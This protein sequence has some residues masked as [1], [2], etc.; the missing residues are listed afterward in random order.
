MRASQ[1]LGVIWW[2]SL[3]AFIFCVIVYIVTM[4]LENTSPKYKPEYQH[5]LTLFPNNSTQ[6]FN[7]KRLEILSKDY[8]FV[9]SHG[10]G[11]TSDGVEWVTD[12][13]DGIKRQITAIELANIINYERIKRG[14]SDKLPIYLMAC[15]AGAGSKPFA[16]QLSEIL[17]VAVTA[18]DE[19][20][21]VD[22]IGLIRTGPYKWTAY[23]YYGRSSVKSFYPKT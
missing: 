7:F 23:F 15:N 18:P 9:A 5:L 10:V 1:K 6:E 14:I 17:G 8:F 13:R 3:V 2:V 20:L 19:W 11:N 21:V 16:K 4:Y 12:E 22:H